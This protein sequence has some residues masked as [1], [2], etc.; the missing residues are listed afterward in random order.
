VLSDFTAAERTALVPV[1][2]ASAGVLLQA[3]A[4]GPEHLLPYWT[5]K[6]CL[7]ENPSSG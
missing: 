3:L 2:D 6:N 1:F 4:Q 5:K 7:A